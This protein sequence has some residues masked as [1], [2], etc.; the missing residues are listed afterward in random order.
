MDAKTGK[1]ELTL[2][3][4]KEERSVLWGLVKWTG[5]ETKYVE[6][7]N[8]NYTFIKGQNGDHDYGDFSAFVNNPDAYLTNTWHSSDEE[9]FEEFAI[10][11]GAT[12]YFGSVATYRNIGSKSVTT[13]RSQKQSE[14]PPAQQNK[15]A[16]Q[17]KAATDVVEAP[18][19]SVNKN[20]ND[21]DGNYIL[22]DIHQKPGKQGQLLK[23][24]KADAERTK[25][26][27]TPVRMSDSQRKA[28]QAGYPEATATVRKDLGKTTTGKAK[29]QEAQ[30]VRKE[31]ANGNRLPL[32]KEKDKKYKG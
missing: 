10:Q 16:V 12:V 7:N 28:R 18:K 2:I 4:K 14:T 23:V 5:P 30:E 24:G 11:A 32:N 13:P 19:A 26:D 31:R 27:G 15:P 3:K 20:S 25:A 1:T 17:Q 6:Y 8:S 9:Q 21:A 22:Y 29:I